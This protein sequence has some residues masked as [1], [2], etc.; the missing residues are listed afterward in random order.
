MKIQSQSTITLE[1]GRYWVGDTC[2]LYP[3]GRWSA[4]CDYLFNS[5]NIQKE[6]ELVDF[7]GNPFFLCSTAYGDGSYD[8][9]KK[10]V[11]VGALLVDAGILS[12]I[13]LETVAGWGSVIM[14]LVP[15]GKFEGG[16]IIE[17]EKECEVEWGGGN[18]SFG[19]YSVVTDGSNEQ[20][21]EEDDFDDGEDEESEE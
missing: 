4:F 11:T 20:E 2:Y 3:K 7:A 8:L 19:D 6:G 15:N 18:F 16:M 14:E 9:V 21:D 12:I 10:G 17:L 5:F 13:P 1:P